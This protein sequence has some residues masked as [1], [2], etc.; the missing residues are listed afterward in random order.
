MEK[1]TPFI[2]LIKNKTTMLMILFLMKIT[3][4][5][6]VRALAWYAGGKI[7][8]RH[9]KLLLIFAC[10]MNRFSLRLLRCVITPVHKREN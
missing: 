8:Y 6:R 3:R 7:S 1:Q 5:L 4:A 9:T 10:I 2:F